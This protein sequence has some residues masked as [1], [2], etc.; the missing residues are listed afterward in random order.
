MIGNAGTIK[1]CSHAPHECLPVL[2]HCCQSYASVTINVI[3]M[4]EYLVNTRKS[5]DNITVDSNFLHEPIT[6]DMLMHEPY[7]PESV[8]SHSPTV[9]KMELLETQLTRKRNSVSPHELKTKLEDILRIENAKSQ[10][11]L[12]KR[13]AS[14]YITKSASPKHCFRDRSM[15]EVP[16]KTRARLKSESSVSSSL[17]RLQSHHS[18]S[19]EDWFEFDEMLDTKCDSRDNTFLENKKENAIERMVLDVDDGYLQSEIKQEFSKKGKILQNKGMK[20]K[21]ACCSVL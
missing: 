1:C 19:D 5:F 8:E 17:N 10:K 9:E 4:S 16:R 21:V 3:D 13:S 6:R 2:C 7:T 15:S 14:Q 12:M 11:F 20:N 18:S